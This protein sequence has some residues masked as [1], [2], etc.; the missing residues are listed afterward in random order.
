MAVPDGCESSR[1]QLRA[2]AVKILPLNPVGGRNTLGWNVVTSRMSSMTGQ[3]EPAASQPS[4]HTVV[5]GGG[6]GFPV[7]PG[8][9]GVCGVCVTP[10][11][12]ARF[13][14]VG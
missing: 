1:R 2:P 11:I 6:G 12:P 9:G 4:Q 10:Q 8:G 13:L 7:C 5:A 3:T 14:P